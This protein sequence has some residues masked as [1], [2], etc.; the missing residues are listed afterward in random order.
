MY[1]NIFLADNA[2]AGRT[3]TCLRDFLAKRNMIIFIEENVFD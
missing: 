1:N 3:E 2:A